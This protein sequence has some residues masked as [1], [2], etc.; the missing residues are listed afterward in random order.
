MCIRDRYISYTSRV[1][2]N[3][4]KLKQ[5]RKYSYLSLSS[6]INVCWTETFGV[7]DG[8][9]SF[10]EGAIVKWHVLE[11]LVSKPGIHG[12]NKMRYFQ[13]RKKWINF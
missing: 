3:Y 4:S 10:S 11:A 7:V 13:W 12:I 2:N 5:F 6:K 1:D 8:I 9:A